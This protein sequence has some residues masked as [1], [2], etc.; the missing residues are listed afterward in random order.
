MN[1]AT[2][3]FLRRKSHA[4]KPVVMIGRQ[5][6]DERI[7]EALDAALN[8]HELVKVRFVN[9]KAERRVLAQELALKVGGEL[10]AVIGHNA[11]VFRQNR[12]PSKRVVYLPPNLGG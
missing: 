10:V 1:S 5:G 6:S 3:S 11:V 2:R 9:F 7:S 12:D 4:L 8:S